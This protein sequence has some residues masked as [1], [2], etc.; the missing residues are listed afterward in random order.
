MWDKLKAYPNKQ[1]GR[2][3]RCSAPP[4]ADLFEQFG[5]EHHQAKRK[6]GLKS[7]IYK[8]IS[9]WRTRVRPFRPLEMSETC[10]SNGVNTPPLRWKSDHGPTYWGMSGNLALCLRIPW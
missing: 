3:R 10:T 2:H 1:D 6:N 9:A 5:A 8:Y 4:C 7:L